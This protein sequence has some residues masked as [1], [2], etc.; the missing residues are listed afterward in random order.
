[1]SHGSRNIVRCFT[2]N[3]PFLCVQSASKVCTEKRY[4][5]GLEIEKKM[6]GK[7]DFFYYK[8]LYSLMLL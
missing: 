3:V 1:V 6:L 2:K 8:I 4:Q 5:D 7:S